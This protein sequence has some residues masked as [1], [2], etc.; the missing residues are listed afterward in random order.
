MTDSER[1]GWVGEVT[2]SNSLSVCLTEARLSTHDFLLPATSSSS[3]QP[4][5]FRREQR[6]RLLHCLQL[7]ISQQGMDGRER[8]ERACYAKSRSQKGGRKEVTR[9]E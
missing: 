5:C 9:R 3:L 7:M 2:S 4:Q 1:E 6:G 8:D